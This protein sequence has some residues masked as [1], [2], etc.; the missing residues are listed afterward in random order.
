MNDVQALIWEL[1]KLSSDLSLIERNHYSLKTTRKENDTEH[2]F[3]VVLLCWYV[4]DQ[5]D[6]EL[7]L[8]KIFKYAIVHDFVERYAGDTNTFASQQMR[9]DKVRREKDALNRFA[10]EFGNF[11][12][13]IASMREY[14]S[15]STKEAEFVWTIDKIQALVLGE[16]DNWRPYEELAISFEKF[17][18]KYEEIDQQVPPELKNLFESV[19]AYC[20]STYYDQ[21][22]TT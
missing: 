14:E 18:K 22:Q 17:S 21:P 7:N 15:K 9:Q 13:M 3:S 11:P 5:L 6:L 16:L 12:E 19:V 10:D 8:S 1:Q 20:K 2:S 4:Y